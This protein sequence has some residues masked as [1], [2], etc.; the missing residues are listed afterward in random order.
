[1]KFLLIAFLAIFNNASVS[2]PMDDMPSLDEI[3]IENQILFTESNLGDIVDVKDDGTLIA[4]CK[5]QETLGA[6]DK[7]ILSKAITAVNKLISG[8]DVKPFT[9]NDTRLIGYGTNSTKCCR[10]F[11]WIFCIK[12]C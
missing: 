9:M 7:H 3:S 5:I 2:S 8:G 6:S 1:M 11:L 10:K 4:K 12:Y